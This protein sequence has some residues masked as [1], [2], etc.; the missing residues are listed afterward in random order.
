MLRMVAQNQS[1]IA[2]TLTR[3]QLAKS[4]GVGVEALRFYEQE[5]LLPKPKRDHVGYRR[6]APE[7]I[8]RLHF[9][10]HAKDLGF[11]LR[12]IHE[13]LELR[14]LAGRACSPICDRVNAKIAEV[15]KKIRT[16]TL[17]KGCLEK[18]SSVCDGGQPI[19]VCPIVHFIE[20]MNGVEQDCLALGEPSKKPNPK[21]KGK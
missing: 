13:I 10:T 16:L 1:K 11:T 12:E 5:G 4:A 2:D 18:L 8:Q 14:E 9:I 21:K 20:Q 15:D 7:M 6:Y 19:E 3:G 17:L